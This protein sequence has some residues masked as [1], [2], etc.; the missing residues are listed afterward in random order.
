MSATASTPVRRP[1]QHSA[2]GAPRQLPSDFRTTTLVVPFLVAIA[3]HDND[4]SRQ[5][6]ALW[7]LQSIV[8]HRS[9]DLRELVGASQSCFQELSQHADSDLVRAAG[10][11]L[12]VIQVK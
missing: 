1:R 10:A 4:P 5:G 12:D 2:S 6:E 7:M 8:Q 3:S 9:P 11:V